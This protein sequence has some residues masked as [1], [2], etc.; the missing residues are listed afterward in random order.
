[1]TMPRLR[2]WL[3]GCATG[4]V[5][6]H[7]TLLGRA[8]GPH[9]SRRDVVLTHGCA[10]MYRVGSRYCGYRLI[11]I[12]CRSRCGLWG[13]EWAV[14]TSRCEPVVCH[15]LQLCAV[16]V[17]SPLVTRSCMILHRFIFFHHDYLRRDP[18]NFSA[19][20]TWLGGHGRFLQGKS[21]LARRRPII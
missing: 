8:G 4:R 2:N 13:D 19:A 9:S 12:A 11:E 10:D 7:V 1:M 17:D 3:H 18:V 14:Y 15:A 21:W 5:A 20:K 6:M 16:W